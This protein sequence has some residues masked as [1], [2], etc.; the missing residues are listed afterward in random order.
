MYL[1]TV[2]SDSFHLTFATQSVSFWYTTCHVI[3]RGLLTPTRCDA[4]PAA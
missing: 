2:Q 4:Q 1:S 3:S